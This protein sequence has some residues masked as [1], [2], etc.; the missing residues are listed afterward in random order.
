ML[1]KGKL[2]QIKTAFKKVYENIKVDDQ[3]LVRYGNEV[4]F[5]ANKFPFESDSLMSMRFST[6]QDIS[7]SDAILEW[8]AQVPESEFSGKQTSTYGR[9]FEL[10]KNYKIG[11]GGDSNVKSIKDRF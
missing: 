10:G 8:L 5:Y 1:S 6:I 7:E 9:L 2:S 4:I 3:E 11:Y